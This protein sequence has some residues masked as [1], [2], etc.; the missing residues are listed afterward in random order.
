MLYRAP[1]PHEIHGGRFDYCVVLDQDIEAKLGEGW[2]LTTPEAMADLHARQTAN[3]QP[4]TA[5]PTL[6]ELR[7]RAKTL[8]IHVDARWGVV[9]LTELIKAKA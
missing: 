2:F 5:P 1:G 3:A 8:G 6:D 4:D 9:K 7:E